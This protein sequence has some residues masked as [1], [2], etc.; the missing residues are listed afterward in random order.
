MIHYY[1]YKITFVDGYYYFGS[2]KCNVEPEKDVYWGSPKTHKDK[3]NTTMFFKTILNVFENGK[4]MLEEETNLIGDLYKT[5]PFCL[6]QHN[7]DNFSTLGLT[8]SEESR[9]RMSDKKVGVVPWNKGKKVFTEET[10]RK[11][12]EKRRGVIHS[13]KVS[14]EVVRRIRE[15]F[16]DRPPLPNVGKVMKN[17]LVMTY[18]RSFSN[19]FSSMFG[20]TPTNLHNIITK[21]SW[22]NV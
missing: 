19:T 6:N 9:K 2:R 20:I 12:S 14:V 7:N 18:E 15:M 3:W 13:S 21:R 11:W 5:D 10:K 16:E 4:E 8:F 1:T 22:I 17:G